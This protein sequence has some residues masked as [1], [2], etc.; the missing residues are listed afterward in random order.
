MRHRKLNKK[1]G[2]SP[3]HR[4][5]LVSGLVCNLI[6]RN[7]IRT[8]LQKARQARSLAEKMVTL[9][10]RQTLAARRVIASRLQRPS[11]VRKLFDEI[12]P[13]FEDRPGGYTRIVKTGTRR[14][15]GAEMCILEWVD[16]M[17]P[18]ASDSGTDDT[19]PSG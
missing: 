12:A 8:T 14:G 7:R 13:R 3:S 16:V 2:R 11:S 19:S 1:L 4:K 9:S 10:R 15:D 18:P 6:E 5:A 17:G